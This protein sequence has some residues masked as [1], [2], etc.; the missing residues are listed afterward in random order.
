MNEEN[1]ITASDARSTFKAF[2]GINT[3]NPHKKDEGK[4]RIWD[5]QIYTKQQ[6]PTVQHRVFYS[7][8]IIM[9]NGKEFEYYI[10]V[11]IH[12]YIYIH[13]HTYEN[14]F[15]IHLKLMQHCKS[16]ILQLKIKT[17]R[18]IQFLILILKKKLRYGEI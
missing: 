13:I 12:M 11:H 9:Y 8:L 18:G 4:F 17:K 5:Q 15:A 7:R 16:A 2:T 6:G 3:F 10:Y 14:H 1:T